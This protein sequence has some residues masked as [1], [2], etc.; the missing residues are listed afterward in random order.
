VVERGRSRDGGLAGLRALA[1]HTVDEG[2]LRLSTFLDLGGGNWKTVEDLWVEGATHV[3]CQTP[4]RDSESMNGFLGVH[5]DGVPFVFDNGAR[6]K[7]VL[8][9]SDLK[10]PPV[11]K[12]IE[13]LEE[14]IDN[15]HL[16]QP[17]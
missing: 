2:Q 3:R 5:G 17:D 14:L 12:F 9:G 15:E 13:H 11:A 8:S 6:V 7:H 1:L 4:F 16:R 10:G